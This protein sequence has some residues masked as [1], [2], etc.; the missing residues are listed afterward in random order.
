MLV[1]IEEPEESPHGSELKESKKTDFLG[2]ELE[3]DLAQK[4]AFGDVDPTNNEAFPED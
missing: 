2:K 3:P 1:H 4:I